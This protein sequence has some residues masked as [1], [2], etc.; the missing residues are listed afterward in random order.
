MSDMVRQTVTLIAAAP[1]PLAE[2]Y[3]I[4]SRF[5][6]A[7]DAETQIP[8]RGRGSVRVDLAPGIYKVKFRSGDAIE[9]K[10]VSL[11]PGSGPVR[12]DSESLHLSSSPFFAG[13]RPREEFHAYWHDVVNQGGGVRHETGT[14]SEIALFVIDE[15]VKEKPL[16]L[17]GL[18]LKSLDEGPIYDF[19]GTE[20][21]SL[22]E[23]SLRIAGATVSVDPGNYR[24]SL[25]TNVIG[26]LE[27]SIYAAEGWQTVVLLRMTTFHAKQRSRRADLVNATILMRRLGEPIDFEHP[28]HRAADTARTALATGRGLISEEAMRSLLHDKF[29]NPLLGLFAAHLILRSPKPNIDLLRTVLANVG[30]MMPDHPDCLALEIAVKGLTGEQQYSRPLV[31]ASPPMLRASWRTIVRCSVDNPDVVPMDSLA[32]EIGDRLWGVGAWLIWVRPKSIRSRPSGGAVSGANAEFGAGTPPEM[33]RLIMRA[34]ETLIDDDRVRDFASRAIEA[35]STDESF[36][37]I[38]QSLADHID[39]WE[40]IRDFLKLSDTESSIL[41]RA[42]KNQVRQ[43]KSDSLRWIQGA[44]GSDLLNPVNLRQALGEISQSELIGTLGLPRATVER[45]IRRIDRKIAR[46]AVRRNQ[47]AGPKITNNNKT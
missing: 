9:E 41:E 36:A 30:S 2:I 12:V 31:F 24:L 1:D 3:V 46:L 4:D 26:T 15:A 25:R 29:K 42:V 19:A 37:N 10:M 14:G 11:A 21:V 17:K 28:Y 6:M 20:S 5:Q 44:I 13:R 16:R 43:L 33:G 32:G 7:V 45:T 34:A 40:L 27:Q 8:A 38:L 35:V 23:D 18:S 39:P 22:M 47:L